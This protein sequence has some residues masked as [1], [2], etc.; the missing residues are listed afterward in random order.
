M[1]YI[2][3]EIPSL[4]KGVIWTVLACHKLYSNE[5]ASD[6]DDNDNDNDKDNDNYNNN[7]NIII[8]IIKATTTIMIMIMMTTMISNRCPH[9]WYG[10]ITLVLETSVFIFIFKKRFSSLVI[11]TTKQDQI[12]MAKLIMSTF[13]VR[14][15]VFILG[16]NIIYSVYTL[17]N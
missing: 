10:P 2:A 12:G 7:Y 3:E 9:Y 17:S 11:R 16:T 1:D 5:C 6:D 15:A 8:I 4:S 14:C 13:P